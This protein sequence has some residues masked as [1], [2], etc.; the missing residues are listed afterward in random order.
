[1]PNTKAAAA[2]GTATVQERHRHRFEF[3]N[4]YR[5]MLTDHGLVISGISPDGRLVEIVEIR[6]HPWFVATQFHPEF[7]SRPNRPHPL[8]RDFVGV[9]VGA[10]AVPAPAAVDDKYAVA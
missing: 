6:D 7:K 5:D 1:V 10:A 2:Y 9:C 3:N 4:D 8:Y